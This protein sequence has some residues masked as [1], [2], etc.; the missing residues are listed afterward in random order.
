MKKSSKSERRAAV[1]ALRAESVRREIEQIKDRL[2][3]PPAQR[4]HFLRFKFPGGGSA[5]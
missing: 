4:T 5:L 3:I 1:K 2:S